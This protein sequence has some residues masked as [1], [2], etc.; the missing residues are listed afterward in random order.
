MYA[1]YSLGCQILQYL[2]YN[3]EGRD[4]S[5]ESQSKISDYPG[6]K[7]KQSHTCKYVVPLH[8]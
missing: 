3:N 6:I 5:L 2:V 8:G 4:Y 7:R 1:R